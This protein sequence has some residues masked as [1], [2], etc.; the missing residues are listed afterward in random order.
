VV[1]PREPA[2]AAGHLHLLLR[3]PERLARA[4]CAAD[5]LAAGPFDRDRLAAE[6]LRVLERALGASARVGARVGPAGTGRFRA[7][8]EKPQP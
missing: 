2:T 1:S 6:F 5:A 4:R 8:P 7:P 3:S